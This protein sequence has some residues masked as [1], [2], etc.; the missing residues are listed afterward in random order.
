MHPVSTGSTHISSATDALA[1]PVFVDNFLGCEE[2]MQV[3]I[4]AYKHTRELARRMPS[5]RGEVAHLHPIFP[6]GSKAATSEDAQPVPIDAPKIQYSK[7]DDE[8]I[9]TFIKLT[10]GT[11]W[12]SVGYTVDLIMTY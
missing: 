5:Y 9:R 11:T 8:A 2:D 12:H 3:M 1:N 10:V 4:W 7:E 6:E